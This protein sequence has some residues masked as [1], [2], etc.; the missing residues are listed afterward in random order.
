[1]K[2]DAA[3]WLVRQS[4]VARRAGVSTATVSRVMNGSPLVSA[5]ARA[6]VE[7]AIEALGYVPHAGARSL[8]L[9]RSGT[10][11]AVIPTLENAIFAA[12]VDA[13]EAE[14]RGAGFGLVISVSNYDPAQEVELIRQML[15][16]GVEGLLLVGNDRAPQ[17]LELLEGSG[18]NHACAWSYDEGAPGPNVGF[19]NAAAMAEVADHLIGAGRRRIGML[20]GIQAGND[21]AR[22]RLGGLLARL[23]GHG[24]AP[25]GVAEVRYS[26]RRAKE[27][28]RGLLAAR[29]DALVCGNDV[30]AYGA[31][32][33]A[34]EAGLAVPDDLAVTG[35]DDLPLS[36][37]IAPGLTTVHVPARR[38]GASAAAALIAAARD[39]PPV[40][41]RRL[42]THL[43]VRA[44]SG[45]P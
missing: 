35:F 10:L 13:F 9:R 5:A 11:G 8:A 32:A 2:S 4:D 29:P 33:A 22:A 16:R 20:A 30:I 38:M 21:R 44:S 1:M 12:G 3:S 6:R 17:G 26:V 34:R 7:A 14:A 41:P 37:E 36:A 45:G 43:V 31:L 18:L 28:A 24:L 27:A 42:E 23:D 19:D 25:A 15:E 40:S 39:G